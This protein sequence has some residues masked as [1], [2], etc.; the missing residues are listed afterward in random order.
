V[1]AGLGGPECEVG[2]HLRPD[3][4]FAFRRYRSGTPRC[5]R[6]RDLLEASRANRV[7]E[8][9]VRAR[10]EHPDHF[11]EHVVAMAQRLLSAR[12][13]LEWLHG[14]AEKAVKAFIRH[15]Q[16][17]AARH[18]SVEETRL[19]ALSLYPQ[20]RGLQREVIDPV[21]REIEAAG[22]RSSLGRGRIVAVMDR[23]LPGTVHARNR[24]IDPAA[25]YAAGVS[26]ARACRATARY[27]QQ[28]GISG[29]D[30]LSPPRAAETI[31][32]L[33]ARYPDQAPHDGFTR[34]WLVHV[35]AR[36]RYHEQATGEAAR[37]G[38]IQAVLASTSYAGAV[39]ALAARIGPGEIPTWGTEAMG[40]PTSLSRRTWAQPGALYALAC[41]EAVG[42]TVTD[43]ADPAVVCGD[44]RLR[45]RPLWPNSPAARRTIAGHAWMTVGTATVI[46]QA[47]G[48]NRAAYEA[49][50]CP[51]AALA[52]QAI[53]IPALVPDIEHELAGRTKALTDL[54]NTLLTQAGPLGETNLHGGGQTATA[55]QLA[56]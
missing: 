13:S 19:S 28:A 53:G 1:W 40:R 39:A 25:V 45:L 7:R 33:F 55:E 20:C 29:D 35:T 10:I 11:V 42:G 21:V 4:T 27:L 51:H 5:F 49:L 46:A 2:A 54:V 48:W 3:G 17:P 18:M 9:V 30:V 50:D 23:L 22:F 8:L 24:T 6:L 37:R 52:A 31:A 15:N 36:G 41:R 38:D 26:A 12:I 16:A 34:R 47:G 56:A 32:V 14:D 43:L 44:A